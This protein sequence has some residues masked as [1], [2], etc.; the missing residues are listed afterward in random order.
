MANA[1]VDKSLDVIRESGGEEHARHVQHV[2]DESAA[3]LK[4]LSYVR[5]SVKILAGINPNWRDNYILRN[6]MEDMWINI[7]YPPKTPSDAPSPR[8]FTIITVMQ[9]A[10]DLS[11]QLSE[12]QASSAEALMGDGYYRRYNMKPPTMDDKAC[13]TDVD[14]DLMEKVILFVSGH[15][16]TRRC[17]ITAE[18]VASMNEVLAPAKKS[19]KKIGVAKAE[20]KSVVKR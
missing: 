11:K 4:A 8:D 16:T 19:H 2:I 15:S 9:V 10:F 6:K 5:D 17:G 14:R 3:K 18:L 12:M 20:A 13:Y 7:V 1:S